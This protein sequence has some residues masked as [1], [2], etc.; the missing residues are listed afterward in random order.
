MPPSRLF[1]LD[2]IDTSRV[3]VAR[4]AIYAVLPQRHEFML[5]D[6]VCHL[7]ADARRIVVVKDIRA[8]DWWAKAHLPGRPIFPGVLLIESAAQMVAYFNQ[9]VQ[10]N[11]KFVGFARVDQVKFRDPVIP[12]CRLVILG[13][14]TTMKTRRVVCACQGFVGDKLV[15]EGTITGMLV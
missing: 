14:V 3:E 9:V 7:D 13:H 1:D 5:L 4:E 6:G 2:A 11:D 8:D 12:P 15:F 10:D